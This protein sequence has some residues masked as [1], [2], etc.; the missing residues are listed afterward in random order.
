[1]CVDDPRYD[2]YKTRKI[3]DQIQPMEKYG[4]IYEKKKELGRGKFG[5]VYQVDK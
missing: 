4:E 2:E 1:M 3:M 5:V